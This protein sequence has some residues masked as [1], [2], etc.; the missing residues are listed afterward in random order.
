MT[1]EAYQDFVDESNMELQ[2]LFDVYQAANYMNIPPLLDLICL[3]LTFDH[4]NKK[5]PEEVS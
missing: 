1:H 4:F 2:Q 3:K 5:T